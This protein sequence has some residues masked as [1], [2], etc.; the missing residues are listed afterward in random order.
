MTFQD[1][2]IKTE[3]HLLQLILNFNNYV[4]KKYHKMKVRFYDLNHHSIK[5]GKNE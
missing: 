2:K 3:L 1:I 4:Y 5:S